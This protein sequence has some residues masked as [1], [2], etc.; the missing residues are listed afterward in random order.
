MEVVVIGTEGA[1]DAVAEKGFFFFWFH[2]VDCDEDVIPSIQAESLGEGNG[3]FHFGGAAGGVEYEM[4]III[5]G[6]SGSVLRRFQRA[7][8][9]IPAR[10]GKG[11]GG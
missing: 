11:I 4:Y 6:T 3:L 7:Y 2:L 9:H 1:D 8:I 5:G 10:I